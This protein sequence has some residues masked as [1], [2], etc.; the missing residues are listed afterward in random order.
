MGL[1]SRAYLTRCVGNLLL[2]N[3]PSFITSVRA[4]KR[5]FT[6]LIWLLLSAATAST[7]AQSSLRVGVLAFRPKAQATEQWQP[8]AS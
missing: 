2:S 5:V 1:G 3:K 7:W 6:V 4:M 8:L